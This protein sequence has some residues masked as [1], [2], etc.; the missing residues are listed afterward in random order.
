MLL[1]YLRWASWTSC[2][3]NTA[4]IFKIY[5]KDFIIF[6]VSVVPIL[7]ILPWQGDTLTLIQWKSSLSCLMILHLLLNWARSALYVSYWDHPMSVLRCETSQKVSS[8][9]PHQ[10]SFKFL[11]FMHNSSFHDN[12]MKK[13]LKVFLPPSWLADF[14]FIFIEMLLGWPSFRFL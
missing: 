12:Q 1:A 9:W 13:K 10:N 6:V 3:T 5:N 7:S 4:D 11:G 14:Q 8:Q 2:F